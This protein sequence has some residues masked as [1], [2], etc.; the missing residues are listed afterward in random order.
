LP[1]LSIGHAQALLQQTD[2]IIKSFP[3]VKTVFGKIGRADTATDPAPLTMIE[4][5]IQLHDKSEWR[6][7]MTLDKLITELNEKVN[8]PGLTNAWVQPIKTRIDMLSTGIKTPIGIKISGDSL[9]VIEKIGQDVEKV[10]A[11]LDGTLSAYSDRVEGGR[12]INVLPNRHKMALYGLSMADLSNV[13]AVSVGGKALQKTIEGRERYSMNL[14]FPQSWRNSVEKL[15]ELPIVTKDGRQLQLGMVADVVIKLGPPMIKSENAR[16]N[17]WTFVDLK[18]NT[19]LAGYVEHAQQ[20][21]A[22]K[23]NL[24]AGYSIKWTGQYEYLLKAQQTLQ[25]IVPMTILIIFVLL[26]FIFKNVTEA[27]MIL[28]VVPFALLGSVWFVW[29]LDYDYSVAV[30]VGMIA[31]AGVAAEFGV[32]MLMYLNEAIKQAKEEHKLNNRQQLLDAI[33]SGAVQRVRPKAMTVMMIVVGLL[34]IMFGDGTGS[35]VMQKIAAPMIG[36]MISAP[37]VSMV[38]IPILVY[39]L[40]SHRLFNKSG[41]KKDV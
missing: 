19:D 35:E 16:L 33:M 7:G 31:L 32:I 36:G 21:V 15:Q 34:P 23:V 11:E 2:A 14:R 10:V 9:Q 39:L 6:A 25:Q 17:G 20:V 24:P 13:L 3:E 27:L 29:W 1:G 4:T 37:I 22:D 40:M 28:L 8:F 12:Y 18:P 5:T 41:E 38:L 30:A 26:Y